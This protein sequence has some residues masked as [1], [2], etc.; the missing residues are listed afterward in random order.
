MLFLARILLVSFFGSFSESHVLLSPRGSYTWS[1]A[2]DNCKANDGYLASD[3]GYNST[4]DSQKSSSAWVGKVELTSKWLQIM[5]CFIFNTTRGNIFQVPTIAFCEM[6]CSSFRYF[7]FRAQIEPVCLCMSQLPTKYSNAY[8]CE[9]VHTYRFLIVYSRYLRSKSYENAIGN[10]MY[11][12]CT[13]SPMQIDGPYVANCTSSSVR[14]V[15]GLGDLV[16]DKNI[17][18]TNSLNECIKHYGTYFPEDFRKVCSHVSSSSWTNIFRQHRSFFYTISSNNDELSHRTPLKCASIN[19]DS[20]YGSRVVNDKVLLTQF[21]SCNTRLPYFL[22]VTD[23][24]Q[25]I[26]SYSSS[27]V[28]TVANQNSDNVNKSI[29][30]T[31]EKD[32]KNKSNT[33]SII[34]GVVCGLIVLVVI[35]IVLVIFKKR[36]VSMCRMKSDVSVTE[37]FSNNASASDKVGLETNDDIENQKTRSEHFSYGDRVNS[38]HLLCEKLQSGGKYEK[39]ICENGSDHEI[40]DEADKQ[41]D[42]LEDGSDFVGSINNAQDGKKRAASIDFSS[43]FLE[44]V[45]D[46]NS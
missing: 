32:V 19:I 3:I 33:G 4:V 29:P 26:V 23:S 36:S 27:I 35:S 24:P 44:H 38:T 16:E 42:K 9:S 43:D 20:P 39:N 34:G 15:C 14:G 11:S 8:S 28:S 22:C 40:V 31:N 17:G 18:W 6:Q 1:D 7:A 30:T 41:S 5:G 37:E 46:S 13:T 12:S 21:V 10:C 25:L 2:Y 45:E